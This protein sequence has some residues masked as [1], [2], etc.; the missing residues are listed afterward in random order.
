[1]SAVL[2]HDQKV[3]FEEDLIELDIPFPSSEGKITDN[4]AWR[5]M[6]LGPPVVMLL[7]I[8][9]EGYNVCKLSRYHYS[10]NL[11]KLVPLYCM[12][13]FSKTVKIPWMGDVH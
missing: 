13:F 5:I 6:A 9:L 8:E 11:P 4:E 2:G 12:F 7:C 10:E 1:M 3:V